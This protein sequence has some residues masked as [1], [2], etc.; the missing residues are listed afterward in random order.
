MRVLLK[1]DSGFA[2]VG[3]LFLLVMLTVLGVAAINTGTDQMMAG[4]ATRESAKT[5]YAA[6]AGLNA[7]LA[8]WP[9]TRYDTMVAEPGDSITIGPVTL[10]NRASYVAV[11][12]RVDDGAAASQI[13]AVRVTGRSP[14]GIFG[15]RRLRSMIRV[16][17]SGMPTGLV[18]E[19]DL[20]ISGNP[21][22]SS[23]AGVHS[24]GS[25]EISGTL[26][27]AGEVSAVGSV[28][29]GGEIVDESGN[30]VE[31]AS[32]APPVEI[33]KLNPMAY[34]DEADYR[35]RDGWVVPTAS[36]A[37]SADAGEGVAYGW[38]W[39]SGDN[40][41]KIKGDEA[42]PGTMCVEGSV[43]IGDDMGT[44]LNPFSLTILAEGH[45]EIS[46]NPFL[47]AAHS[48]DLVVVG[49]G[50]LKLNGNSELGADN[51]SGTVYGGSQCEVSGTPK[52]T[53]S[54]ICYGDPDPAGVKDIVSE[55]KINGDLTLIAACG[56]GSGVDV[57]LLSNRA[58]TQVE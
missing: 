55:N 20:L 11:V 30:P 34:C 22:L 15:Q 36:P 2:L 57:A 17:L 39:N 41:Y 6:E 47:E 50:D 4:R 56:G 31:P 27:V 43:S 46:G 12:Q 19:K 35:L 13:F 51:V 24:N 1:N 3:T 29:V 40:I 44:P 54:V 37:D 7:I 28:D 23:C 9:A 53:G 48:A 49:G 58:W 16:R 5:F 26:T 8:S 10:E 21:L 45:V 33:P 25:L 52:I 38:E 32:G 42:L 18:F 14:G